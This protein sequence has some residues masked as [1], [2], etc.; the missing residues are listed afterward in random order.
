MWLKNKCGIKF[1]NDFEQLGLHI[2]RT[3]PDGLLTVLAW[4]KKRTKA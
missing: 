2:V 3:A 4:L 1:Q